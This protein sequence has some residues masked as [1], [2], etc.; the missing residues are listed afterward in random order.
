MSSVKEINST[1]KTK[2]PIPAIRE[3]TYLMY[4]RNVTA[5][6]TMQFN[7]EIDKSDL[8]NMGVSLLTKAVRDVCSMDKVDTIHAKELI[9]EEVS[10]EKEHNI[11]SRMFDLPEPTTPYVLTDSDTP[12]K[13]TNKSYHITER[14]Y[15][16]MNTLEFNMRTG[17]SS[18]V[19]LAVDL[20][21]K[22]LKE[23]GSTKGC[24]MVQAID[25]I[26][27]ELSKESYSALISEIFVSTPI[28]LAKVDE[29]VGMRA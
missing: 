29:F 3:R 1:F 7:L 6:Y 16:M 15:G 28:P 26:V 14:S 18:I 23:I 4:D 17:L 8:V 25:M 5:L 24:T 10:G 11:V 27:D 20:L 19:N 12:M 9:M 2:M 13:R 21:V 22:S